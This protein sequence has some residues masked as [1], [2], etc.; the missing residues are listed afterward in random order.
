ML[1]CLF[2]EFQKHTFNRLPIFVYSPLLAQDE[3]EEGKEEDKKPI[4]SQDLFATYNV[5]Y[6][7]IT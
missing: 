2:P 5:N 7:L 4:E 6:I 1:T 3:V